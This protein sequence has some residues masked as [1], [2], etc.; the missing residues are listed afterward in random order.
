M[1]YPARPFFSMYFWLKHRKNLYHLLIILAS[2]PSNDRLASALVLQ[3]FY[4][5]AILLIQ[6]FK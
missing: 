6:F 4:Q 3:L 2:Y 5:S 1:C